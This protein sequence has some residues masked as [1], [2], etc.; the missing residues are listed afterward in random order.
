LFLC[1]SFPDSSLFFLA[2][3]ALAPFLAFIRWA[4]DKKT[5]LAG[6]FLMAFIYFGGVLYWIP[7]VLVD[8]GGLG[9]W[10]AWMIWALMALILGVFLLPF[11]LISFFSAKFGD[12]MLLLAAPASWMLTELLR[13]YLAIN[14]F[15]WASLGYS[16]FHFPL[17]TQCADIGGVYLVSGLVVLIN[18]VILAFFWSEKRVLKWGGAV[19]LLLLFYGGYR[20]WIWTP[21]ETGEIRAGMVQGNI[22]LQESREYYAKKYFSTLPGLAEKAWSEQA[23]LLVLP[24]AQCPYYFERDFYFKTF[25]RRKADQNGS[26]ILLNSTRMDRD[27]VGKY[28]NSVY[29]V[30]PGKGVTYIYDKVHLVPFGEFVPFARLLSFAQPLVSE[31]SSFTPGEEIKPGLI[32]GHPFGTLICYED[33]FPELGRESARQGA[34]ILVNVTNDLWYGDTAAPEQHLQIA[35]FRS[36]ETRRTLL[37][38]ANSGYTAMVD[39]WGRVLKKTSLFTEDCLVCDAALYSGKSLFTYLGNMPVLLIILSFGGFLFFRIRQ[40]SAPPDDPGE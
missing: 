26:D 29:L 8:F 9:N 4:G 11:T 38:A 34:E 32:N 24:E 17:L 23:Q 25:W 35:S 33:V 22:A 40:K 27:E 10:T 7:R 36:I 37:R 16:Q 15:P 3:G 30:T 18:V 2:W 6:H 5:L 28:Y 21:Q 13:N 12:E 31:V 19:V 39:P 20:L 1:L 14:G